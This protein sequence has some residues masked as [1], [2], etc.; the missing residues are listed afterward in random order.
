MTIEEE[1][2]ASFVAHEAHAPEVGPL[3]RGIDGLLARRRRQRMLARGGVVAALTAIALVAVPVALRVSNRPTPLPDLL[4]GVLSLPDRPLNILLLG[5]EPIVDLGYPSTEAGSDTIIVVHLPADRRRAFLIAL[6]RDVLVDIPGH[7]PGKINHA[8]RL[9]GVPLAAATVEALT[10]VT[11]DGTVTVTGPALA[12]IVDALGGVP[13]CLPVTV[14]SI[15]TGR[16]FP[17]GCAVLD[18][19]AV[20]DL[21]RQRQDYLNGAYG[22]DQTNVRVLRGLTQRIQALDVLTD[23][24]Q[25]AD[26]LAVDGLTI[27]LP[28]IE[29]IALALALKDIGAG[30]VVGLSESAFHPVADG[31]PNEMLDP[32]VAPQLFQALRDGT[33]TEFAA[34]HPAWVVTQ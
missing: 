22:R 34:R 8:Y 11:L 32:V 1:L 25:V 24:D 3:R 26:L 13:L 20:A 4:P 16:L 19:S 29:P 9:G 2:R 31:T 33:L 17:V 5:L 14:E 7:G 28:D 27:D 15:H 21:T 18:G 6:E 10:G 23:L 12:Q 30:D